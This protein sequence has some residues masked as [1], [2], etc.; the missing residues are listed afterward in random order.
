MSIE[1]KTKLHPFEIAGFGKAPF[2]FVRLQQ[3]VNA[4][5][6]PCGCC[7]FCGAGLRYEYIF[8]SF[9][10]QPEFRVG[11]D[12]A[13]KT[14]Q[15][16][17]TLLDEVTRAQKRLEHDQREAKN[18]AIAQAKW[19]A[20]QDRMQ[21][22]RDANGGKLLGEIEQE[23]KEARKLAQEK[24]DRIR[25]TEENGWIISAIKSSENGFVQSICRQL[26]AGPLSNFRKGRPLN[27]VA[28]I[29]CKSFGRMN[30][31]KYNAAQD[32]FWARIE[33]DTVDS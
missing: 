15:E 18:M 6:Y 22:E 28:E 3:K 4:D 19:Q 20:N 5:G 13:E 7:D 24:A 31:K 25:Y 14:L 33:S 23:A 21:A 11:S 12:C 26:E 16:N 17:N 8:R 32:V 9:D 10:N 30:S 27:M 2:R 29:Y 1:T